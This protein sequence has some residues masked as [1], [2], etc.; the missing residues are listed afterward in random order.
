MPATANKQRKLRRQRRVRAKIL[1]SSKK[2]RLCVFRSNKHIYVQLIDDV[3]KKTILSASDQKLKKG[4]TVKVDSA[5]EI[6]RMIAK[7]ALEKKIEKVIF[8]RGP[9]KYHGRVKAV[10]EGAREGGLKF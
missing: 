9:Y 8:D 7:A 3:Q 1:G 4:K 2:P 5:K 6:G 10:A